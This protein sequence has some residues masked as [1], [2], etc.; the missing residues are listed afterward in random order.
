MSIKIRIIKIALLIFSVS[1]A[2]ANDLKDENTS[3]LQPQLVFYK[4]F[5]PTKLAEAATFIH[6]HNT[7]TPR[8]LTFLSAPSNYYRLIIVPLIPPGVIGKNAKLAVKVAVG[9]ETTF[10]SADSDPSFVISDGHRFVGMLTLD[11]NNYPS[12]APCFGIEGSSGNT[13]TRR[14]DA[15]LPKPSESNYPGRF[16]IQLSLSD[17]IL[18]FLKIYAMGFTFFKHKMEVFD[19]IVVIVS[20]S[21]DVAFSAMI[22][23]VSTCQPG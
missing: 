1:L 21:L 19:G 3:N 6:H 12:S 11:K 15:V 17:R 7:L 16:E 18:L 13:M 20:F 8:L 5:T 23:L 9:L 2:Q 22:I 10:G 14:T 4:F